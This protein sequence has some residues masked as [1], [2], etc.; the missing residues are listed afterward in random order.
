VAE[1]ITCPSGLSGRVRGMKVREEKILVDR[2]LAKSGTQLDELLAAC[3]EETIEPGP[4]TF[5]GPRPDWSAVLQGDRFYALLQLRALTYGPEY[6][7]AVTC[8]EARCRARIHWE[9]SLHDLPIRPLSPKSRE[10]FLGGNRFPAFLDDAQKKVF[11]RLLTGADERRLPS[12][13][14]QAGDKLLSATLAFRLVQIEG[15]E[16]KDKRRFVEELSLADARH[17]GEE[18]Q[19]ADCG[20]ETSIDIECPECFAVQAVD[21]PF[22]ADFFLPTKGRSSPTSTSKDGVKGSSTSSGSSTEDRDLA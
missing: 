11:F 3:W 5:D 19:R 8:R 22:E 18:F 4:Y 1:I 7:F 14:R 12:L 13:K 20:V 2:K 16:P 21:L 17:L 6:S 10:L 15:V 9:F